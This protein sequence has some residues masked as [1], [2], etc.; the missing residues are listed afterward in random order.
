MLLHARLRGVDLG[1]PGLRGEASRPGAVSELYCQRL[2]IQQHPQIGL[3]ILEGADLAPEVLAIVGGHHERLNG[4]GYPLGLSAEEITI[5]PRIVA[6]ADVYDA[7]T[8]S[9]PYRQAMTPDEALKVIRRES[10]E[11]LLDPEVVAAMIGFAREWEERRRSIETLTEAR[12]ESL[13]Q[14]RVA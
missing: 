5:F 10:M 12:A 2:L 1:A 3:R 13:L 9:R 8:T 11:G 7:M 4:R 6:V 14:V